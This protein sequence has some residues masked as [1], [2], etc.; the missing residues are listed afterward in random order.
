MS[1]GDD[2]RWE[3]KEQLQRHGEPATYT[4]CLLLQVHRHES[5]GCL[6]PSTL[7]LPATTMNEP[8]KSRPRGTTVVCADAAGDHSPLVVVAG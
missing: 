1:D 7:I 3:R 5:H 2:D 6:P 4:F 8:L